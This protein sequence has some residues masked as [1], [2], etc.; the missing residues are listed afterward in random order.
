[1]G[2]GIYLSIYN[3]SRTSCTDSNPT[4]DPLSLSASIA[5]L[6][7]LTEVIVS[8]GLRIFEGRQAYKN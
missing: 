3:N 8:P 4:M 7:T 5:G 6:I 2:V 1:M